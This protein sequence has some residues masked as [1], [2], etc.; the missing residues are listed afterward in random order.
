M[1]SPAF[2]FP[3]KPLQNPTVVAMLGSLGFHGLLVLT[4]GLKPTAEL[5]QRLQIIN[6][7]PR[8]AQQGPGKNS[9][10][11]AAALSTKLP[12]IS[13]DHISK[14]WTF[15][16]ASKLSPAQTFFAGTDLAS[17]DLNKSQTM[18]LAQKSGAKL[19]APVPIYGSL[20]Q[21]KSSLKQTSGN[22][23]SDISNSIF[24]KQTPANSFGTTQLNPTTSFSSSA[25]PSLLPTPSTEPQ[26]APAEPLPNPPASSV[27][28]SPSPRSSPQPTPPEQID[29]PPLP[30]P[31]ALSSETWE[32]FSQWLQSH[33]LRNIREINAQVGP[34]LIAT[35]PPEACA[36]HQEGTAII[37]AIYGPNGN[38]TSGSDSIKVLEPAPTVELNQ[39]A[40]A[41]V[42]KHHP[43][44]INDYQAFT[45]EVN[46]PYSETVCEGSKQ[47][48]SSQPSEKP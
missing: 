2:G 29:N 36:S 21:P 23:F 25:V 45:F 8:S 19:G 37:A 22:I 28:P 40:R 39:A 15:P 41:A 24:S 30:T 7:A 16:D 46:I 17:I 13:L 4:S 31:A 35:Y 48:V 44:I 5:P 9:L 33:S 32:T 6:L 11:A 18:D 3:K 14:S 42:S 12:P 38:L 20:P 34:S 27:T 43:P 47:S 10:N 1:K 26:A